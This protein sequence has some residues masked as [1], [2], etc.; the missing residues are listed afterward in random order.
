LQEQDAFHV[1]G[2]AMAPAHSDRP[3]LA[4]RPHADRSGW[5]VEAWW[6]NRPLEKIGHFSTYGAARDWITLE[7]TAYFV[8]REIGSIIKHPERSPSN[9]S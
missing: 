1:F 8:L 2:T 6:N 5:Y 4:V 9:T 7:S 3:D